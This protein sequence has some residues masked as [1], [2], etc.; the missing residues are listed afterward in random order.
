MPGTPAYDSDFKNH[1]ARRTQNTVT[2]TY[3][4]RDRDRDRDRALAPG[5]LGQ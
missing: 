3:T 1:S 2:D 4:D 5:S